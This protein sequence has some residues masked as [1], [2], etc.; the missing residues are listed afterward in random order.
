M[1]AALGTRETCVGPSGRKRPPRASAR[2]NPPPQ[3]ASSNPRKLPLG[4]LAATSAPSARPVSSRLST[5]ERVSKSG[6]RVGWTSERTPGRGSASPQDSSGVW[7][8]RTRAA[9]C[10]VSSRAEAMETTNTSPS[11]SRNPA[12]AGRL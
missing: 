10:E 11:A 3:A 4:N 1:R 12:A 7:S 6:R 8:G 9:S 2:W 5:S